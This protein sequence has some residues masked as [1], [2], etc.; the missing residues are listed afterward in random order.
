MPSMKPLSPGDCGSHDPQGAGGGV[1]ES[2]GNT[3]AAGTETPT[4]A[5]TLR[6][7]WAALAKG[8]SASC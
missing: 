3:H 5:T 8:E 4:P 7:A 2:P 6:S 1:R